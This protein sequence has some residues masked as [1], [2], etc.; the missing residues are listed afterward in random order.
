M[1]SK[2]LFLLVLLVPLVAAAQSGPNANNPA[3]YSVSG[4]VQNSVTGEPIPHALVQL[5]GESQKGVFTDSGGRFEFDQLPAATIMMA[6]ARKPGFLAPNEVD[7][8]ATLTL[9]HTGPDAPAVNLKLIPEGVV[10]GRAQKP[11][12]EPIGYLTV[13]LFYFQISDGRRRVLPMNSAQTNEDGEFRIAGLRPGTYYL[14]AG[15]RYAPTWIGA[16][17]QRAREAAY[18]PLFYP[19]VPDLLS[20]APLQV[21]PGQQVEAD[22]SLN[23]D[24]I[25]RIS[26][27][28]TGVPPS[29]TVEDVFPRV[30]VLPRDNRA[31]AI[32]VQADSG[33]EFQAKVPAGSY[34]VRADVD[35]PHG[36]YGGDLPVTVQSDVS[37]LNLMVAPA[38][39]LR[40]EVSVQRTRGDI[41]PSK[42]AQDQ[43]NLHFIGQDVKG[44]TFENAFTNGIVQGLEPGVYA[45]EVTPLNSS[46]YVD[47]A[48]CGGVDLLREN[49]TVGVGTPSIRVTLRDDGGTLAG[50]VVSEGHAAP[51]T[52]VVIPDRAP[53]Q[54]KTV[55]AGSNG[56]FQSPKLAPGDYAVLAFDRVTGIE[57]ANPEVMSPYLPNATRVSVAANGESRVTVNLIQTTK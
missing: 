4:I 13:Q 46:L 49:L 6:S 24:P 39:E 8:N 14:Q 11:D 23:P 40:V 18:R 12:G 44:P 54:I 25:F 57:Y 28:L 1:T 16:P 52:V 53:K 15:P 30:T 31:V 42:R 35:T 36:P 20:A 45:V 43:V 37:G 51:G 19:G 7:P 38:P 2:L 29:D 5:G 17:G 55:L 26:G 21:S 22:L 50:N 33:N 32:P 10:F 3:L 27:T 48:Q 9:V 41:N 56:Q 47:S 34:I